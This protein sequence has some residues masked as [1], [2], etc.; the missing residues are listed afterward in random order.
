MNGGNVPAVDEPFLTLSF[1][2]N[3]KTAHS[4]LSPVQNLSTLQK[5]GIMIL[6]FKNLIIVIVLLWIILIQ[7]WHKNVAKITMIMINAEPDFINPVAFMEIG[8]N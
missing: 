8:M 1:V 7:H 4:L 6:L 3:I 5:N 2:K